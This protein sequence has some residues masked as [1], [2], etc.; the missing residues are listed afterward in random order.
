MKHPGGPVG[1]AATGNVSPYDRI[2]QAI[3]DGTFEPGQA[4]TEAALSEWCG[5]SRTPVREALGRLEQDGLV[6][7]NG[8]GALVMER[9]PEEI[10]GI[11]ETR[12]ALEGAAARMAAVHY[13]V[14]D[15]VRLERLSAAAE[16]VDPADP[17]AMSDANQ[18][19]HRAIWEATHNRSLIDLL[20]RLHLHVLRYPVTTLTVPGR[21]EQA[22]AEHRGILSAIIDRDPVKA[23]EAAELHFSAARDVRLEMWEQGL[24]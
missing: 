10:L 13:G 15:R 3:I 12:I 17:R 22:L 11:Y 8:R 7:R 14:L 18:E 24:S 21:W 2:K 23:E 19:F 1:R 9:T 4:L 20:D 6:A 16:K 5:V